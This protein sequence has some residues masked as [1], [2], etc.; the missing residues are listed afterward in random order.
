MI[1]VVLSSMSNHSP[2]YRSNSV[3]GT[4]EIDADSK[5]ISLSPC[6]NQGHTTLA[7]ASETMSAQL[8][9][10]ISSTQNT[11]VV[12]VVSPTSES[13]KSPRKITSLTQAQHGFDKDW[14]DPLKQSPVCSKACLKYNLTEDQELPV[15]AASKRQ[16]IESTD[17][18]E[19][20]KDQDN[21]NISIV[22]KTYIK[23]KKIRTS[24]GNHNR[25]RCVFNEVVD[26]IP[27]P[28]RN[29]Y[30]QRVRTRLWSNALEIHRNATRNAIEFASE[31]WDWR[32]VA[33]DDSMIVCGTTGEL[34][35]PVHCG[36]TIQLSNDKNQC[37]ESTIV[38]CENLYEDAE[39]STKIA[40]ENLPS[41]SVPVSASL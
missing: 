15:V 18:D 33:D 9:G 30:S 25:K 14:V 20:R 22:S 4:I 7:L 31:G 24:K 39:S 21:N 36:E 13:S 35:H 1:A 34:I 38:R 17:S 27:I 23:N 3:A 29:E 26:V 2:H 40:C 8:L 19:A 10:S 11:P 5:I 32:M 12:V 16:K 28:M 6:P 41:S 37:Q